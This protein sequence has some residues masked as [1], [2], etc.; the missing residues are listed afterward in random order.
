MPKAKK[1]KRALY[2]AYAAHFVHTPF[3]GYLWSFVIVFIKALSGRQRINGLGAINAFAHQ[4]IT[5]TKD[6]YINTQSV[7]KLLRKLTQEN[8]TTPITLAVY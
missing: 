4:L 5:V 2:F 8:L 6:S 1:G 3:L 7:C